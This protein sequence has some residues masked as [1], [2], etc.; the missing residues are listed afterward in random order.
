MKLKDFIRSYRERQGLSQREFSDRCN[1]SHSYISMLELGKNPSSGKPLRP[2][3]GTLRKVATGMGM[4]LDELLK[5][6]DDFVLSLNDFEPEEL[7]LLPVKPRKKIPRL[8]RIPCG[9]PNEMEQNVEGY[10]DLPEG[11]TADY[12]LLCEGDSMINAQIL[13]GDIV[14]IRQQEEVENG[15]IA[16]VWYDGSTTLKRFYKNGDTVTLMPENPRYAPIFINGASLSRLKVLG[17][18]VGFTRIFK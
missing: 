14:Y 1:M 5:S 3:I 10:D 2:T 6:V 12:T 11:I 13:D 9:E 16:A 17:K 15:E 7:G 4:S 8:G 18:A